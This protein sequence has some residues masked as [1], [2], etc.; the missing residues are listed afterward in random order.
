MLVWLVLD[1]EHDFGFGHL[2]RLV[3]IAQTLV[4]QDIN[5]CFH[6]ENAFGS[7]IIDFIKAN[8]LPAVCECSGNP[9]LLIIDTYNPDTAEIFT[10]QTGSKIVIFA[11]ESTPIGHPDAIVQVSPTPEDKPY[12][13]GVPILE[14][15]DSP[16]LRNEVVS[17]SQISSELSPIKSGWLVSLGGVDDHVYHK[18]LHSL[19]QML[20]RHNL[21]VTVASGST[22][23]GLLAQ[24][25]GFTWIDKSLDVSAICSKYKFAITGAGVT[26]WELAFL[27]FPGFVVSVVNNQDFQLDY[28]LKHKIRLGLRI[29]SENFNAELKALIAAEPDYLDFTRPVDGRNRVLKFINKVIFEKSV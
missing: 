10:K 7:R 13:L 3:A 12:P 23:V 20:N 5:F 29:G 19:D 24:S 17:Y 22:S 8:N 2:S 27:R 21:E 14:F 15:R 16:V 11:D 6:S 9:D 25:L 1:S 26:A 28:L 18:L 4:S